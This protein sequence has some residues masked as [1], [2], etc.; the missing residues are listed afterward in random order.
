MNN[1]E[2]PFGFSRGMRETILVAAF[3]ISAI[4]APLTIA[5]FATSAFA[6]A[7]D[8]AAVSLSN[9]ITGALAVSPLPSI[10]PFSSQA[11]LI[12]QA[13][14]TPIPVSSPSPSPTASVVPSVT[15][16]VVSANEN[17]ASSGFSAG[18]GLGNKTPYDW[19]TRAVFSNAA[20]LS[21]SELKIVM[22][23]NVWSTKNSAYYGLVVLVNG[24]QQNFSYG[25]PIVIPAN[26]IVDLYG[27]IEYS[28]FYGATLYATFSNTAIT[29]SIPASSL[30]P[31]TATTVVS[32]SPSTVSPSPISQPSPSPAI[33]PPP[34]T[35]APPVVS[36]SPTPVQ[37]PPSSFS[38]PI[39]TLTATPALPV[40]GQTVVVSW[41][42]SGTALSCTKSGDWS[43][44][45]SNIGSEVFTITTVK[46]FSL[47]CS[48]DGGNATKSIR[49]APAAPSI[50]SIQPTSGTV[51]T[52]VTI[53]GT[54]F[55]NDRMNTVRFSDNNGNFS[56]IKLV[57]AD[58]RTLS[59]L[60]P[61][62]L[63]AGGSTAVAP[64][65]NT[66]SVSTK[67]F[68]ARVIDSVVSFYFG[69]PYLQ[70]AQ[71]GN[72]PVPVKVLPG[73]FNVQVLNDNGI[74]NK[75]VFEV[76]GAPVQGPP[77]A[78]AGFGPD[79]LSATL[80]SAD[81]NYAGAWNEF[82][83]ANGRA[84]TKTPFDWEVS[85]ILNLENSRTI[86]SIN[87]THNCCAESW[88]TAQSAKYPVV[89]FENGA[90]LNSYYGQ[91]LVLGAGTHTLR[92][93]NQI[94][95]TTF[96]GAT[97]I[98]AF[99][100]GT[101][102][103]VSI[104]ASSTI[105]PSAVPVIT[106]IT[107]T[108]G[109]TSTQVTINA[110]GL[111]TS[112]GYV[113]RFS[114]ARGDYSDNYTYS[115][116]GRTIQF[117]IPA[118]LGYPCQNTPVTPP[119][120]VGAFINRLI[121]AFV[122]TASAQVA[123]PGGG[124][125]PAP[126]P[127]TS[128]PVVQAPTSFFGKVSSLL[129]KTVSAQI[130]VPNNVPAGQYNIKIYVA[131]TVVSNSMAFRVTSTSQTSI[132]SVTPSSGTFGTNVVLS[133]SFTATGN[134]VDFYC[135]ATGSGASSAPL[136]SG[137]AGT[138]I[139]Y[140]I[141]QIPII[142]GSPVPFPL[143]CSITVTNSNGASNTVS[144]SVTA[145]NTT[146][147]V[148]VTS[149]N[150]GE[151]YQIGGQM[152]VRWNTN[153]YSGA[154]I[155]LVLRKSD[156][157]NNFPVDSGDQAARVPNTGS[158]TWTIGNI[159]TGGQYYMR[160]LCVPYSTCNIS[161]SPLFTI[162]P[163]STPSITV[164]SP[165]GG[166]SFS[167]GD[168]MQIRWSAQ[169]T[170]TNYVAHIGLRSEATGLYV[171][172][173]TIGYC[174][175]PGG[176]VPLTT[177]LFSYTIPTNVPAGS[178]KIV[179][180]CFPANSEG[181]TCPA[182]DESNA[183][184]TIS[185]TV[186]SSITVTSPTASS[187][188]AP[189][190][191]QDIRWNMTGVEPTRYLGV[192]V[193]NVDTGIAIMSGTVLAGEGHLNWAIPANAAAGNFRIRIIDNNIVP[194]VVVESPIFRINNQQA[195]VVGQRVE[196]VPPWL[197]VDAVGVRQDPGDN[198]PRVAILNIGEQ[199]VIV[200]APAQLVNGVLWWN[201]RFDNGVVGWVVQNALGAV[202]TGDVRIFRVDQNLALLGPATTTLARIT[203]SSTTP[204]NPANFLNVPLASTTAYATDLP[205]MLESYATCTYPRG[206]VEC[207]IIETSSA[208]TTVGM[209]RSNGF[210]F[211]HIPV[212]ANTVT[213]VVFK[214]DP[215]I[216]N[217][218]ASFV[219]VAPRNAIAGAA[220]FGMAE[221]RLDAAQ[222]DE[223]VRLDIINLA[224]NVSN[225]GNAANLTSCR[226]FDGATQVG[227]R[228]TA[229]QG[230]NFFT[231]S[232]SVQVPAF[233]S[234]ILNLRCNIASGATGTYSWTTFSQFNQP[235]ARGI[236]LASLQNY[237]VTRIEMSGPSVNLNN[238]G[239][240]AVSQHSVTP[241][242]KIVAGGTVGNT[243]LALNFHANGEAVA[244]NSVGLRLS[245]DSAGNPA[246]PQD[247]VLATIWDGTTR[248]GDA[249]FQ[250]SQT[251]AN[252]SFTST[253]V[254]PQNGDKVLTVKLDLAPIGQSQAV[255]TSGHLVVIDVDT[256]NS[257]TTGVGQSSGNQLV[258]TGST[259][260]A[261][262]RVNKTYP[263]FTYSTAGAT[264]SNGVN[265]LLVFNVQAL[266][267]PN[268]GEV[269]LNRLTFGINTVTANL[270]AL[271]LTGP[272]G[273][274]SSTTNLNV[275]Q[276]SSTAIGYFDSI[277]NNQDRIIA[278][279]SSKTF[280]LRG[281]ISLTGPNSTGSVSTWLK[282][283]KAYP[284]QFTPGVNPYMFTVVE[285]NFIPANAGA[286]FNVWSPVSTSTG[287]TITPR[288]RDWVNGFG[289]PGCF[290]LAGLGNDCAARVIA[291]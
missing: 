49:V 111:R 83:P 25:T 73:R 134:I 89:I 200:A 219:D 248:V 218:I 285:L 223:N 45:V 21:A 102:L 154:N 11:L 227:S 265:D 77:P 256:T 67:N 182:S 56:D 72:V 63:S 197:G 28:S 214:Y 269:V 142:V 125:N 240:L 61:E 131:D 100:D 93:Y 289:L 32:P 282:G 170:P 262:L 221:V 204:N 136:N 232:P 30:V 114:N 133:G 179:L 50:I 122:P 138:L 207:Q 14:P 237:N 8:T 91:S 74:G 246:S 286:A 194:N 271:T 252:V 279:G 141:P 280:T 156:T 113:V 203:I 162:V 13:S 191:T 215:S 59:F 173:P 212:I 115:P 18:T 199:G 155:D 51:G 90:Q 120:P 169:N 288:Y 193:I 140:T 123:I 116:D 209:F 157:G 234:K 96:T 163:A 126:N 27:Q 217:L 260:V 190:T 171:D 24:V 20:G 78:P 54:G 40:L 65:T 71:F 17:Y 101:S 183:P 22:G 231:L 15:A 290:A 281:T 235:I 104:P 228:S 267:G 195:F 79:T 176:C 159:G 92:L 273:N 251:T 47:L 7:Y 278:A 201:V 121:H 291:R 239:A 44:S 272:N 37:P 46:N 181:S 225:G 192:S 48:N 198:F 242:Y 57:S 208:F 97:L 243:A 177:G 184:F 130:I 186:V 168:V 229:T 145:P 270:S 233:G 23:S 38:A 255:N 42:V 230:L 2:H 135:P 151:T 284:T 110:T 76:E 185:P 275:N 147:T 277:S 9:Q 1:A 36:P 58:T 12:A 10:P 220:Q 167:V 196:I 257:R 62:N 124:I 202:P 34:P 250:G 41:N 238:A 224:L 16:S 64:T 172:T 253:V 87:L 274:V 103:S 283:D 105:R 205:G 106:S 26:G 60:V 31:P 127:C 99:A 84:Y 80:V 55:T 165:N 3:V 222:V 98:F 70:T 166:E 139:A 117:T 216:N 118:F 160:V 137:G 158:Y 174:N 161:D 5:M 33:A 82:R 178:Y 259:S 128:Q 150:G 52:K 264:A 254:I 153:N 245:G 210:V 213:K 43:G 226:L 109:P 129:F 261:G 108:S 88:S 268:G 53:T 188:W 164:L 29:A 19:H 107:P 81:K 86:K 144:F 85:A 146:P 68:L 39:I 132:T 276:F 266:G 119:P 258:A 95:S 175:L 66:S 69:E 287:S 148:T 244:L 189:G 247:I 211:T 112:T 152:T 206:G 249:V 94:E 263:V 75:A 236:G 187:V 35:I 241:G 143:A 149:P 180:L 6:T 4:V